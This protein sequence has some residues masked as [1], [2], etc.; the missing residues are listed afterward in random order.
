MKL[1]HTGALALVGWYLM[2]PPWG[3]GSVDGDAPLRQWERYEEYLTKDACEYDRGI[4]VIMNRASC[5]GCPED[6]QHFVHRAEQFSRA[7]C[8]KSDDPRL[9]E[10]LK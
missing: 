4:Q 9:K 3:I 5:K 7:V 6:A 1:R 10:S 8:V 2:V